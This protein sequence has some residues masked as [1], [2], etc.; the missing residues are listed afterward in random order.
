MRARSLGVLRSIVVLTALA[1]GMLASPKAARADTYPAAVSLNDVLAVRWWQGQG[2]ELRRRAVAEGK[3]VFLFLDGV[4]VHGIVGEWDPTYPGVVRFPLTRD[5]SNRDDW[6]RLLGG[7]VFKPRE[8][9]VAVGFEDRSL[10]VG[11][12]NK[13]MLRALSPVRGWI[14]LGVL[15]VLS[16]IVRWFYKNESILRDA[17]PPA[18]GGER[19]YSLA[20]LQ[21]AAWTLQVITA[22][23]GIWAVTGAAASLT[24][25]VLALLGISSG[26]ALTSAVV[27]ETKRAQQPSPAAASSGGIVS[28]VVSDEQGPALSRLQIILWTV[29]LSVVFWGNVYSHLAMPDFDATMLVLMGLSAGTY[30]GLK[31]SR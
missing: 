4:R 9:S 27:D 17:A 12:S 15:V 25:S 11:A 28:D 20:R 13:L 22:F 23:V 24:P 29:V 2:A 1:L 3:P 8:V 5:D 6:A 30:V 21:M 31:V 10:T 14:L 7:R 26:T 16:C 18:S 19:T